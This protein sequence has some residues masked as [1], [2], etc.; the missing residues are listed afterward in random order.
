MFK[1]QGVLCS[2][3]H[4]PFNNNHSKRLQDFDFQIKLTRVRSKQTS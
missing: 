3:R 2:L 4:E 1:K